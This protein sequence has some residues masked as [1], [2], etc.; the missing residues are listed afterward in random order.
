MY[1]QDGKTLPRADN[2]AALGELGARLRTAYRS[3]RVVSETGAARS[4]LTQS[5]LVRK[6]VQ[7]TWKSRGELFVPAHC[8]D[9]ERCILDSK[10]HNVYLAVCRVCVQGKLDRNFVVTRTC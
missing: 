3:L 6:A 9:V 5:P 8:K 7:L 2:N 1:A 4:Q 10:V